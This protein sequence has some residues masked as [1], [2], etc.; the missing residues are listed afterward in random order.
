MKSIIMDVDGK[1]LNLVEID[2]IKVGNFF[3]IDLG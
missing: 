3:V 2:V 1:V